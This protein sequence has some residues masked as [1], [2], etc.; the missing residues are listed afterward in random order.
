MTVRD[1]KSFVRRAGGRSRSDRLIHE[2][3]S[4]GED[5]GVDGM[6]TVRGGGMR[7]QLGRVQ[8]PEA[9]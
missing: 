5:E 6:K 8:T 4:G 3:E 2:V 9:L 1:C 7:L